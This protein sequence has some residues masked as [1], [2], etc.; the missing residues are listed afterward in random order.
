MFTN[1]INMSIKVNTNDTDITVY[2]KVNLSHSNKTNIISLIEIVSLFK[3]NFLLIKLNVTLSP[4]CAVNTSFPTLNFTKVMPSLMFLIAE[5]SLSFKI[6][7]VKFIVIPS[8]T[9]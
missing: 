8:N 7:W 3:Y 9:Y 6:I 4:S 2:D 5:T 1:I